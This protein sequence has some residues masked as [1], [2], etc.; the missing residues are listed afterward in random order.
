MMENEKIGPWEI[1]N[2]GPRPCDGIVQI[3]TRC[4][5]R[6][7]A[8]EDLYISAGE[9]PSWEHTGSMDD[10]I[11]FRRI[12]QLPYKVIDVGRVDGLEWFILERTDGSRWKFSYTLLPNGSPS[13]AAARFHKIK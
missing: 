11:A 4:E 9:W 1:W 3:Q 5:T 12:T 10:I 7:E 8:E 6:K 13:T 2:G